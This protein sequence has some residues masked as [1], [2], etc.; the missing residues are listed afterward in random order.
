M[1]KTKD[2]TPPATLVV[3]PDEE[4]DP[5]DLAKK[6][7]ERVRQKMESGFYD[8]DE[9]D[10]VNKF[11]PP[12]PREAEDLN[13]RLL[14]VMN[15]NW[16]AAGPLDFSTHR[17]GLGAKAAVLFKKFYQKFIHRFVKMSLVRQSHFNMAAKTALEEGFH[18][19][20]RYLT[21]SEQARGL[22]KEATEAN[23]RSKELEERVRFLENSLKD[24][25]RQGIF[26]KNRIAKILDS[27]AGVVPGQPLPPDTAKA[28]AK[29]R[30]QLDSHDYTLFE[31]IH[32]GSR[33][34]IKNKLGVYAQWFA[35]AGDV[36][37]IGCGRGE[38]LEL[39]RERG[40]AARG[41][42]INPDM[43]TECRARGYEAQEADALA[44]LESLPDNSLGGI[45]AI[46]FVEHLTTEQIARFFT[47]AL[48][49][50]KKGGL[51]ATETVNAKCLTTFSGAF[52]LDMSHVKPVH[53]EAL[54]FLV[55]RTGFEEARIEYLN[56]YP[57]HMKL[58]ALDGAAFEGGPSAQ[59]MPQF[60]ANVMKLND[61]LYGA[62]DYAVVGRK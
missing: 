61:I 11:R 51:I 4:F 56:P 7:R 36:L 15:S 59:I 42:D 27:V 6:I 18:L 23:R 12:I 46:Q 52:Y 13:R 40:V 16:D 55:E 39:F 29:E 10:R 49:K 43:V 14:G 57:D 22:E 35:D 38:L 2:N 25:D 50:L 41:I 5:K 48:E 58:N 28:L 37:D 26:M 32:R 45:T 47:L 31:N 9:I 62:T 24:L 21:L 30:S 19:R 33:E 34:E 3:K 44:Y 20:A 54:K 60:N 1:D 17:A 53:P 8:P